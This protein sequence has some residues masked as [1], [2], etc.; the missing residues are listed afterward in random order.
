MENDVRTSGPSSWAI[1]PARRLRYASTNMRL[2]A[3]LILLAGPISLWAAPAAG[4][5]FTEA[6]SRFLNKNY[7]AALVEYDEFLQLYPSSDLLADVQYR[8]AVCLYQLGNYQ[9]ASEV[10]ADVALRFRWTRYINAVPLWQGLS[11]YKLSRFTPSLVSINE[12]LTTGKDPQLVPRALL[13]KSLDLEELQ[14]L[15]EAAD[16]ARQLL[17]GYPQSEVAGPAL[18]LLSSLLLKDKSY[19]ELEQ[20]AAGADTPSLPANLRQEFLWN[21]AEGLWASNHQSDAL[22]IYTDLRDARADISVAAYRRLFAAAES[23][24]DLP[25]ME[26]I[27]REMESHFAGTPQVMVDIWA[28][29]GVENY[30]NGN[31]Q[32]ASTYLQRAWALRKSY[33]VDAT[34]PIYLAKIMQDRKDTEGAKS[35]LQDYAAQPGASSESV[36]LALGVLAR[37]SGELAAAESILSRFLDTYPKSRNASRAAALLADVELRQGKLD[38]SSALASRYLQGDAAGSSRPDFLRLQAEI[39]RQKGSFAAAADLLRE[40]T[41]LAPADVDAAVDLLEMQFLARDYQSVIKGA[42]ALLSSPVEKSAH[43]NTC[44]LPSGAQPG[45]RKGL[46][47]RSGNAR[48]NRYRRGP[49]RGSCDDRAVSAVLPGMVLFENGGLQEQRGHR[50]RHGHGLSAARSYPED[51]VPGGMEPFQ[52]RRF[53]QGRGL[54]LPGRH[55]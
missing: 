52:S 49:G 51:P 1:A 11:Q 37:D 8:R 18:V 5:L 44:R 50:R 16:A 17:K 21:R 53:R 41:A 55:G 34:V 27:G 19:D 24:S 25:R 28:G 40:Y 36:M 30:K 10:L 47:G 23:Q 2:A 42:P 31:L 3:I 39:D 22:V 54:F 13:C 7:T 12:Y 4:A 6:E 20:L 43:G 48:K 14:K 35:M 32:P 15:P 26:S 38:Q 9:Q 45:C 33:K 46:C 29:L